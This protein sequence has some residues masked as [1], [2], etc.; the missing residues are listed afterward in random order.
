MTKDVEKNIDLL[1]QGN[2]SKWLE[3]VQ[4]IRNED[5]SVLVGIRD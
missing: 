4:C 1:R 2:E 5:Q 3:C